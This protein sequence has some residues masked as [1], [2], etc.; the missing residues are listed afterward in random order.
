MTLTYFNNRY[1][2]IIHSN[3]SSN[4]KAVKLSELMTELERIFKIPML[5]N[6]EW[7][8]KNKAIVTLYRNISISRKL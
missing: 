3:L 5:R 6:E 8:K 2:D 4:R 1:E 7:E